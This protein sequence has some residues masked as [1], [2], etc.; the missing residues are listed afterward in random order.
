[1]LVPK[2][3]CRVAC[4]SGFALAMGGDLPWDTES[5]VWKMRINSV[6]LEKG[7]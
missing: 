2:F 7:I 6:T 5:T 1:M 4:A 3:V